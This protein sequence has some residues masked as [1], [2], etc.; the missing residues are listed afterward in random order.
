MSKVTGQRTKNSQ[1][2]ISAAMIY[3]KGSSDKVLTPYQI[4]VNEAAGK[5]ALENPSLLDQ[6]GILY[7]KAK[8][9]VRGDSCFVFKKGKSRSKSVEEVEPVPSKK[10]YTSDTFRK[11]H[12][13][14]LLEDIEG[15]QQ[16]LK[17]KQ[18]RQS[19]AQASKDWETCDKLQKE[20]ATLRKEV[21]EAQKEL[22]LFQRKEKKSKWYKKKANQSTGVTVSNQASI[23]VYRKG[24]NNKKMNPNQ[25]PVVLWQENCTTTQPGSPSMVPEALDQESS[26]P[27]VSVASG[28]ETLKA[29]Q[30]SNSPQVSVASE[31]DFVESPLRIC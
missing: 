27:H 8:E 22:K 7:E 31:Q 1:Q 21:F 20:M 12:T 13:A 30:P 3:G 10:Q 26:G 4:S 16:Q 5:L 19:K 23:D 14:Q 29:T 17:Y 2:V 18:L 6:R 9:A 24:T 28:Q 25:A 15:K 11:E